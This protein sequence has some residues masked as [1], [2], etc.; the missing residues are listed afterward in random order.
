MMMNDIINHI[1]NRLYVYD[2][3]HDDETD[4]N[5]LQYIYIYHNIH[6]FHTLMT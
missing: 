5:S 6:S 1:T 4:L 3:D 2:D